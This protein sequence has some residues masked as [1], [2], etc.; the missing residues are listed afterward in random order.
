MPTVVREAGF[1]VRIYSSDHPPPHVHVEKAGAV[2]KINL[3]TAQVLR[4]VGAL[5]DR[6]VKRAE[7]IVAKHAVL[8]QDAWRTLHGHK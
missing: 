6:D 5:S 3:R 8:L 1:E 2:L 4:I 7:R